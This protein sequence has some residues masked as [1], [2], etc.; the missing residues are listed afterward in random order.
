MRLFPSVQLATMISLT[1]W[2]HPSTCRPET[3]RH[4]ASSVFCDLEKRRLSTFI[5]RPTRAPSISLVLEEQH[6]E[7]EHHRIRSEL[8]PPSM[9]A[10]SPSPSWR[11]IGQVVSGAAT[12]SAAAWVLGPTIRRFLQ[13]SAILDAD[14]FVAAS[15]H[16][17]ASPSLIGFM[18]W[19]SWAHGTV[20]IL[21]L[22]AI[23]ASATWRYSNRL[24]LPVLMAAVPGGLL[25]NVA[26]KHA[27]QRP[28]PDW[29]YALQALET[30]SFPSGHT[31]GATLF[32][33][34]V[35]V[36]LWPRVRGVGARTALL[37]AAISMVLLVAASRIV[38]GAHFMTD[39]VAAVIEAGIWL[40]ICLIGA[41]EAAVSSSRVAD[42]R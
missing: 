22:T 1:D 12:F 9:K 24:P 19:V 36:W 25:L 30:Y 42:E 13:S 21:A 18:V 2:P 37:I 34:I 16:A 39:C 17:A 26:I 14:R 6:I 5:G 4:S 7:H 32:Y 29:G 10:V 40:A 11:R 20:G 31:A 28:R 27:V 15:L 41:P 35:L 3:A 38:L 33:G 8:P 23:A